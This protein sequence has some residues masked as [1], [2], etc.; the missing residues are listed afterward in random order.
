MARA[1]WRRACLPVAAAACAVSLGASASLAAD[2]PTFRGDSARSGATDDG[3]S[4]PLA[5]AWVHRPA[6]PPRPAWPDG[7]APADYWHKLHGLEHSS[8]HDF[9]FHV[10]VADGRLFYGSS[11]D[12]TVRCLDAETG[13]ELWSCVTEGPVRLAPAV[14]GGAVYV[15]SDD[16]RLYCL[17]A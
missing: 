11:A 17:D 4:P 6:H 7:P 8:V 10:A 16:G 5:A 13:V 9:A 12:D 15:G 2:W 14:A 3:L 1:Q